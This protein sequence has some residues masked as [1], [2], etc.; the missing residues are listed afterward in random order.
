M[1]MSKLP[2]IFPLTQEATD[3]AFAAHRTGGIPDGLYI[4]DASARARG[5]AVI[6]INNEQ[7]WAEGIYSPSGR[8]AVV[9]NAIAAWQALTGQRGESVLA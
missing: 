1:A 9:R 6:Y 8:D 5:T 4:K 3:K 7:C 2:P